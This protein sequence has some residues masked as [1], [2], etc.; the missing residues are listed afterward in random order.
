MSERWGSGQELHCWIGYCICDCCCGGVLQIADSS[1]KITAVGVSATLNGVNWFIKT[2]I[3]VYS[4]ILLFV[5][6]HNY[7]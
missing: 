4:K 2:F 5:H 6:Y 7:K 1:S 3:R